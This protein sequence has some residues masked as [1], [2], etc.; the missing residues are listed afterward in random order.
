MRKFELIAL[1]AAT[2]V[3]AMP[4]AAQG[5]ARDNDRVP[6]GQRP[7]AGLCRVWI[8]GV[9]PG[10]QPAPTSCALA[11]ARRPLNSR[12]IYGNITPRPGRGRHENLSNGRVVDINGRRCTEQVDVF[13]N[14]TYNCR[15]EQQAQSNGGIPA[16]FRGSN[17]QRVNSRGQVIDSQG[18]V[19]NRSNRDGD[20]DDRGYNR[21]DDDEN[22]GNRGI[23]RQTD[24]SGYY[25]RQEYGKHE[26]H[27]KHGKHG[28]G[29][30][31]DD[32]DGGN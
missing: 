30:G 7:P 14:A 1:T 8:D 6:P 23:N 10:Q 2:V 3:F 16:I 15:N 31:D 18:R 28:H 27:E 4:A 26:K 21:E 32:G 12:V 24:Q 20:D 9:P 13:G 19:I 11:E 22:G 29:H 17:G 5:R 25:G